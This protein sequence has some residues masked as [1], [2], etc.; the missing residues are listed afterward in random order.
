MNL[1][2]K[3]T[4]KPK[5]EEIV[6]YRTPLKDQAALQYVEKRLAFPLEVLL[7]FPK[8]FL[9]E[10]TDVCNARC[11]MCGIDFEKKKKAVMSDALFDRITK[12]I[13][14]HRNH[15]E[16]VMLYL[17]G[18]PLLDKKL[19]LKIQKMKQSG[20]KKVN[21]ATNASLLNGQRAEQLINAGLDEI[22]ITLDSLKENIF[23][24]IRRGLRFKTVY[25]NIVDFIRLRNQLNPKLTIR[26]QMVAQDL[27][28]HEADS[29]IR[30]WTQFLNHNDQVVVQEAHNW[31]SAVKVR[32]FGDEDIVNN[33]PC[34]AI[35]GTLCIHVD[36]RVGLCCMDTNSTIPVGNVV[37]QTITEI[38]SGE[39]LQRMREKHI[40]GVRAEIPLCNGCTVWRESKHNREQVGEL[41]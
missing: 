10:T 6:Y 35:W 17:D 40:L 25:K 13:S 3:T 18:E 9:I 11:I 2:S 24:A 33:I 39:P 34:I 26:I 16:K 28:Y 20:I 23:E 32:K 14:Q 5:S 36:G 1:I 19:S 12:E 4:K 30:H 27:N 15:V 7:A 29:F 38:W 21:I 22:Y 31:A 8:F 37:S 41:D